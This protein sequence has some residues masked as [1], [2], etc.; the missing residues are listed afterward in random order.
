MKKFFQIA[1]WVIVIGGI[2]VWWQIYTKNIEQKGKYSE[3]KAKSAELAKKE[4]THKAIIELADKYNAVV[5]WNKPLNKILNLM[6]PIFTVEV[7][8]ALLRNDN[9][10]VLFLARV[11]DIKRKEDKYLV[12][13][14]MDDSALEYWSTINVA[15]DC[16]DEQ[17]RKIMQQQYDREWENFAV[18]AEIQKV[19][20]VEFN[21]KAEG[22]FEEPKIRVDTTDSVF[23]VSGKCLDLLFVGDYSYYELCPEDEKQ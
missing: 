17:V 23:I 3:Q 22:D 2:I 1:V 20:K 19:R 8:D 6:S 5:D 14:L 15:L 11:E 16:S 4:S 18:I 13:F 7:E 12:S 21:L 9:R 10:P